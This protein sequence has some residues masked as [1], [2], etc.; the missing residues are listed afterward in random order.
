MASLQCPAAFLQLADQGLTLPA[1]SDQLEPSKPTGISA[2]ADCHV[3]AVSGQIAVRVPVATTRNRM[4]HAFYVEHPLEHDHT[5]CIAKDATGTI[6]TGFACQPVT[7]V[8]S[9]LPSRKA[10]P[11]TLV[12][13]D[14]GAQ[15]SAPTSWMFFGVASQF[16]SLLKV[17]C[18]YSGWFLGSTT[19]HGAR[20]RS[21]KLA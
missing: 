20:H 4:S 5:T 8:C 10:N 21:S 14:S 3:D 16:A 19:N 17:D 1:K 13:Q 9:F 15:S 11:P 12:D 7:F 2:S 6:P 18:I